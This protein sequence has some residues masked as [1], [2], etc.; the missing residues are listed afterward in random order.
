M[1]DGMG[2]AT[3]VDHDSP[4]TGAEF[5][6]QWRARLHP[7]PG[8][9]PPDAGFD[10]G[11]LTV[12][13]EADHLDPGP[14]ALA[15]RVAEAIG[16]L[17]EV[18]ADEIA[19]LDRCELTDLA[20]RI[21][22]L[23]RRIDALGV[24]ITTH[25]DTG[26]PYRE[27]GYFTAK[28]FLKQRL[29]LS[30]PEAHRRVLAARFDHRFPEWAAAARH[31]R[32]G[33]AQRELIARIAANPHVD[34]D[35][36]QRDAGLLLDDAMA[37]PHADF[38]RIARTWQALAD[39][40]SDRARHEQITA[41]RTVDLRPRP[42]G[43]WTLTGTLAEL[44]AAEFAE[45][46]GRFCDAEWHADRADAHVRLGPDAT[47]T[48]GTLQRTESQRRADALLAM[49]RAAVTNTTAPGTTPRPT[50]NILIDNASWEASL[51]GET[52][53]PRRYRNVICRTQTGRRLHPHDAIDTAL[54]GHIRRVVYDTSGTVIDLGRRSRLFRGAAREAATL[55]STT[56]AW[57]G[58]DR[59]VQWCDTDHST[60]WRAHGP[61][62][63]RNGQPLCRRH[64]LHKENGFRVFRD[65]HGRWHTIDAQGN[66]IR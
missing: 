22:H 50:V 8:Q 9:V 11:D 52:P 47:I 5:L 25:I 19:A 42:D 21:E 39:P 6:D 58:C 30:G 46:L 63:P 37:L 48:A 34:H 1:M 2:D 17:A 33:I 44:D 28:T 20:E 66:E 36:L 38:D 61:T 59:P 51:H 54:I 13:G 62:V 10:P 35:L 53:D 41:D 18:S 40:D 65:A 24:S 7:V 32:V 14:L 4:L 16:P 45:I 55:M 27:Q 12:P 26:M 56:C 15:A 31:G 64:N 43:G 3:D 29:Q 57:I 60:T 23:R 49:A